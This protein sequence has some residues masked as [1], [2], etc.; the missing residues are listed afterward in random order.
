MATAE[1]RSVTTDQCMEV[2][3]NKAQKEKK[4]EN[5]LNDI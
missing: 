2:I 1:E 4:S 5:S 3:Q